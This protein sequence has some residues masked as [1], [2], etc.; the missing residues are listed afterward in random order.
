MPYPPI[1]MNGFY[2]HV[3]LMGKPRTTSSAPTST[4]YKHK[5]YLYISLLY[6]YSIPS[7]SNLLYKIYKKVG[8]IKATSV[9]IF[10]V[11]KDFI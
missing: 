1:N 4:R 11:I 3:V 7:N 8:E 2:N 10:F 5:S 9:E 6:T